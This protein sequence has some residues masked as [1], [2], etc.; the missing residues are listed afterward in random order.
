MSVADIIV[1]VPALA[2]VLLIAQ[3]I[4]RRRR[5]RRM[6]WAI[7]PW[8]RLAAAILVP[9]GLGLVIGTAASLALD[10]PPPGP[11]V[12]FLREFLN[13]AIAFPSDLTRSMIRSPN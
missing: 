6:L 3:R 12:G 13:P 4:L 11:H 9:G 8:V 10:A 7:L 5:T 1:G 2:A